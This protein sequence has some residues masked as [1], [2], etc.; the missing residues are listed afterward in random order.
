VEAEK[1]LANVELA[2]ANV[3]R[4]EKNASGEVDMFDEYEPAAVDATLAHLNRAL[5]LAPQDLS[6]HQGRL[7]VLEIS[8]RYKEMATAL[9]ESCGIYEG[10]E[11]PA[12]WLDYP[13]EL[14]ELH[15]YA[16][17]LDLMMV[18]DKHFPNNPEILGNIG[19]FLSYLKRD[20]EAI[21]YL[22]RAVKL[23]PNDPINTWDLGREYDYAE[24]TSMADQWYAKGISLM[25]DPE[26]IKQSQCLYADFIEKKLK[27]S[28]RACK[29]QKENCDADHQTAC[30]AVGKPL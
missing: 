3:V 26:Q 28:A 23:A 13:S 2:G 19:A 25:T 7:H 29:L 18:L 15:E 12:A 5:Q 14:N 24:E 4:M 8:R 6:V 1:C 30:G 21:S 27:D 22:E 17:A 20:K 16:P 11:V 9:D 10:K